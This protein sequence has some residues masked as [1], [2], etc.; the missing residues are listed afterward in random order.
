MRGGPRRY[1]E[2][3]TTWSERERMEVRMWRNG[4][5]VRKFSVVYLRKLKD[6]WIVIRRYD[7]AH[8]QP[9]CH[10][11]GYHK[12]EVRI[13]DIRGEPSMILTETIQKIEKSR[14][15]FTEFYFRN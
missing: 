4:I 8:I 14:Q 12:G 3:G 13:E 6:R 11:Y 7:N 9:H 10:V 2:W 5:R 1:E 15:Q